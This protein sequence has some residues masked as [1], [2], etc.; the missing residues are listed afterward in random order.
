MFLGI[1]TFGKFNKEI[2]WTMTQNDGTLCN[3]ILSRSTPSAE[4]VFRCSGLDVVSLGNFN[5]KSADRSFNSKIRNNIYFISA[6]MRIVGC[7]KIIVLNN[8]QLNKYLLS[9]SGRN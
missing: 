6:E 1:P 2:P 7:I 8:V 9:N 3:R 5:V 4:R